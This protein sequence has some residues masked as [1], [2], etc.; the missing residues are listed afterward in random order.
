MTLIIDSCYPRPANM[1]TANPKNNASRSNSYKPPEPI[2]TTLFY[3]HSF[4]APQRTQKSLIKQILHRRLPN[5]YT[6]QIH[7]HPNQTLNPRI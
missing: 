7:E 3:T 6:V 1:K 5:L 4:N 2:E